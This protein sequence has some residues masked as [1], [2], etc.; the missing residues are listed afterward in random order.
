ME[1]HLRKKEMWMI[2]CFDLCGYSVSIALFVGKQL[3][4][5]QNSRLNSTG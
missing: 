2:F 1:Y 4:L 3:Q 5:C